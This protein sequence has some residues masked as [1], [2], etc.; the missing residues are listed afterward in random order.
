LHSFSCKKQTSGSPEIELVVSLATLFAFWATAIVSSVVIAS[1]ISS[2]VTASV[3]SS[4]VV[5]TLI[6]TSAAAPVVSS[7]V[8]T[9]VV[10]VASLRAL[11]GQVHADGSAVQLRL[12]QVSDGL[13]RVLRLGKRDEAKALGTACG[14][15]KQ[16]QKG[17][18][19]RY[20]I[21]GASNRSLQ[22]TDLLCP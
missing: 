16:L 10:A 4:V 14:G 22:G 18:A 12:V 20:P 2:V 5:A 1:V 19:M 8:A 15:D 6:V 13:A 3:V 7:V 11:V 21:S 17:T 9:S